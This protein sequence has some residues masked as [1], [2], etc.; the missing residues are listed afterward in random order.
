MLVLPQGPRPRAARSAR[1]SRIWSTA[2]TPRCSATSTRPRAAINPDYI[3]HTVALADGRVLRG[4]LRTDGD[5]LIVG[6]TTGRTT[7]VDRADVE[8][9]SPSSV[10]IMPEGL[11]TA[12]GPE[13]LRDLL[14][15]LLT[16]PL[17]PGSTR[18]RR[19]ASAAPP[20]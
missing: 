14:T 3:A 6:D 12:L 11:D 8:T 18:T 9:T 4:T 15:F 2:I 20:R 5:R 19:P 13:K 7:I 17:Q 16:D 10:S 1:T